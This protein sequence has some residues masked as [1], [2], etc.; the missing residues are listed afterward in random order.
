MLA[1]AA[2][3]LFVS[4]VVACFVHMFICRLFM[5]VLSVVYNAFCCMVLLA[6][7]SVLFYYRTK[8][9]GLRVCIKSN[10]LLSTAAAYEAS[11]REAFGFLAR[12]LPG[13]L[14]GGKSSLFYVDTG[15]S[16]DS[17][18]FHGYP[19][20]SIVPWVNPVLAPNQ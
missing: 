20:E 19:R 6:F 2:W 15:A 4:S 9:F 7:D 5:L 17:G 18:V 16:F 12:D 14:M 10:Q 3:I 1:T 11:A 8:C 13:D